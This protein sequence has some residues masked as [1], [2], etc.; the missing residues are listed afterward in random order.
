MVRNNV[1]KLR[2]VCSLANEWCIYVSS[3]YSQVRLPDP[4]CWDCIYYMAPIVQLLSTAVTLARRWLQPAHSHVNTGSFRNPLSTGNAACT[5]FWTYLEIYLASGS[6]ITAVVCQ[7][8]GRSPCRD[9]SKLFNGSYRSFSN[10][11]ALRV[12]TLCE[13]AWRPMEMRPK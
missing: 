9:S 5:F 12:D 4:G 1:Y 13:E 11:L 3:L 2:R 10:S 8:N 7:S 6:C